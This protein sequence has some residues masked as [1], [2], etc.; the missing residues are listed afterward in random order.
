MPDLA[1]FPESCHAALFAQMRRDLEHL[2]PDDFR[3]PW[4][5]LTHGL[6]DRTE[7]ISFARPAPSR[8]AADEAGET[9]IFAIDWTQ[10]RVEIDTSE[11]DALPAEAHAELEAWIK[12]RWG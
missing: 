3:L 2:G 9:E 8:V 4:P 6:Y 5:D 12:E 10:S 1:N 7:T 11:I